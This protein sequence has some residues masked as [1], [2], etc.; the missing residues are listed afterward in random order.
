MVQHHEGSLWGCLPDGYHQDL[1]AAVHLAAQSPPP[2]AGCGSAQHSY[3]DIAR[4][5]KHSD[6]ST[7]SFTSKTGV[8]TRRLHQVS[9]NIGKKVASTEVT[10]NEQPILTILQSAI[11]CYSNCPFIEQLKPRLAPH[12]ET[13]PLDSQEVLCV[14]AAISSF[15]SAKI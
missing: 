15:S 13:T 5:H 11:P 12:I 10:M 8:I 6:I 7:V 3:P 1:V 14:P 2:P 4:R 9:G